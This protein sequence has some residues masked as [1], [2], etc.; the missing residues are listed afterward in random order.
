[1]KVVVIRS[2]ETS[3]YIRSTQRYN[4]EDDTFHLVLLIEKAQ[5]TFASMS[6]FANYVAHGGFSVCLDVVM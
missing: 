3:V 5:F 1:M 6:L 4:E 2:S